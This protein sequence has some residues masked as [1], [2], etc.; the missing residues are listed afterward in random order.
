LKRQE[1]G[2]A[3]ANENLPSGHVCFTGVSTLAHMLTSAQHIFQEYQVSE[4]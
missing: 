3:N 1:R 2:T 4:V